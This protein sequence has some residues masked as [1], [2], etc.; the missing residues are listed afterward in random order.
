[1]QP[2]DLTEYHRSDLAAQTAR[3]RAAVL[4]STAHANE[5]AAQMP[6]GDPDDPEMKLW[7]IGGYWAMLFCIW[8]AMLAPIVL[9]LTNWD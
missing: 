6:A 8:F 4:A 2:H 9:I 1:M 3:A 7:N 5:T